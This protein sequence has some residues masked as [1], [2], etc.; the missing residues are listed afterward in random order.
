MQLF[1]S[2][3]SPS[4][5]LAMDLEEL[6]SYLRSVDSDLH[7]PMEGVLAQTEAI[8]DPALPP[9]F[10][11]A[12]LSWLDAALKQWDSQ[13]APAEPLAGELRR[14]RPLLAAVAV[15]DRDFFIPGKHPLHQ[16]MDAAQAYAVGWHAELGRVGQSVENDIAQAVAAALRW[17]EVPSTDLGVIS[18]RMQ[19]TADKAVARVEK[20]TRRLVETERGRTRVAQSKRRA[21]EMINAEMAH[22]DVPTELGEFLKGPWYDSAQLVLSK[23]GEQSEEWGQM[24]LTTVQLLRS[25]Q[26]DASEGFHSSDV[27]PSHDDEVGELPKRI[28]MWLLSLQHDEVATG[29]VLATISSL[30]AKLLRGE[31][32]QRHT[33]TPIPV[34][35]LSATDAAVAKSLHGIEEGQWLSMPFDKGQPIRVMLALCMREQQ[36]LLFTNHA[37]LKVAQLGFDEFARLVAAG[38][39]VP[40]DSG[41][42]FSR[43]LAGAVGL[44]TQ[45]DVDEFT[46]VAAQRARERQ[47]AQEKAAR[48]RELA[49]QQRAKREAAEQERVRR[50]QEERLQAQRQR[51]LA[52]RL[53]R[54]REEAERRRR[55]EAE[56][57]KA[58]LERE[59]EE[60]QAYQHRWL[61]L[62]KGFVKSDSVQ[63]RQLKDNLEDEMQVDYDSPAAIIP[64]YAWLGFRD[65][66]E[67]DIVLARLA[68]HLPES[69]TYVFVDRLGARVRELSGDELVIIL[70]RG[71][72]DI[73]ESRSRFM[74]DL[75]QFQKEETLES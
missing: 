45:D 70:T 37:G 33:I 36:Q 14:L 42:S 60:A 57:D 30:H 22:D 43:A 21:A 39:A 4:D 63:A 11:Q 68:V 29:Q 53:Q 55:E 25:V 49:A 61:A 10:Q 23:Y 47:L 26:R 34:N 66:D 58:R 51:E 1:S 62:T 44:V 73:V 75:A 65:G 69:G 71:L 6:F 15:Q 56:L 48:E 27:P 31:P 18:K 20:M 40:L 67:D 2:D 35:R 46:G 5:E 64:R 9:A 59:R 3:L 13:F 8:G 17:F 24:K 19:V 32:I 16:L 54:E 28:A 12:T 72:I 41:F 50:E 7:Y 38:E 52:E 74:E